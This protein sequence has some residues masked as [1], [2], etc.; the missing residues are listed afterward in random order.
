MCKVHSFYLFSP[1]VL[2]LFCLQFL[3]GEDTFERFL[4]IYGTLPEKMKIIQDR[5]LF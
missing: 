5:I 1:A 4:L 2:N 3:E